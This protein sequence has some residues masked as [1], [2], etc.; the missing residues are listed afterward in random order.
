[1]AVGHAHH[2]LIRLVVTRACRTTVS[3]RARSGRDGRAAPALGAG[4]D[5]T[6]AGRPHV[7]VRPAHLTDFLTY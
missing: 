2:G 6:K 1:M 4:S 7:D 3:H 5:E